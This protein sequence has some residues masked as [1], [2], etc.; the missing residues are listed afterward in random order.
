MEYTAI[1]LKKRTILA[2]YINQ[3]RGKPVTTRPSFTP[4]RR[5]GTAGIAMTTATGIPRIDRTK[6][7]SHAIAARTHI[8][9]K[10]VTVIKAAVVNTRHP[11][12][13]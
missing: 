5:L 7:S 12:C 9:V 4:Q 2:A 6:A 10:P 8:I 11:V 1:I 13:R 3:H